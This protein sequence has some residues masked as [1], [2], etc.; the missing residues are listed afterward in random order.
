[1]NYQYFKPAPTSIRELKRMYRLLSKK[2]HPDMGSNTDDI[3]KKINEEH[4]SLCII[5]NSV[6]DAEDVEEIFDCA[7]SNPRKSVDPSTKPI[8]AIIESLIS[9]FNHYFYNGELP[10][11]V[12]TLSRAPSMATLGWCSRDRVWE[13]SDNARHYEINIC[14]D[15]LHMPIEDICG[16]ILHEMVHFC[17]AEH[18]IKDCSR[19]SQYHNKKFKACAEKYG[20]NVDR[21]PSR[22]FSI[23]SLKS[24]TRRYLKTLDLSAFELYRNARSTSSSPGDQDQTEISAVV[25]SSST[26]KVK[27][28]S[29]GQKAR[30]TSKD[31]SLICGRC[32]IHMVP[33]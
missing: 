5:L 14:P 23:T 28:E 7:L 17:N 12:V 32:N 27:C 16:V 3:M 22:G 8:I 29:C 26:R 10:K 33:A 2:Y 9:E 15:H 24:E 21:H 25:P 4:D 13:G 11:P 30:V 1:M 19:N 20:L 31:W 6:P 18:G